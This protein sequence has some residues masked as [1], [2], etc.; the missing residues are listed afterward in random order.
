MVARLIGFLRPSSDWHEMLTVCI[1]HC[2]ATLRIADLQI[3]NVTA[4]QAHCETKS[5]PT[6]RE[7][8]RVAVDFESRK[9]VSTGAYNTHQQ[10]KMELHHHKLK[11][12][13]KVRR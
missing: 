1:S 10:S 8:D 13:Q 12:T 6:I 2:N 3:A 4:A 5:W 7:S 9:S 11:E